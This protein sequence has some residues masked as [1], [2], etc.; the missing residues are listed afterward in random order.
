M[1]RT[2]DSYKDLG[3]VVV[4]DNHNTRQAG[5]SYYI[6][7]L[8]MNSIPNAVTRPWAFL[9]LFYKIALYTATTAT[10]ITAEQLA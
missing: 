3:R 1:H 10:V 6:L 8:I 9:Y 5:V 7:D 2:S 4:M